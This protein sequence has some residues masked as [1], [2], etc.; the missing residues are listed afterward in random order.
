MADFTILMKTAEQNGGRV[1]KR[2][3]PCA[4]LSR[5]GR[6]LVNAETFELIKPAA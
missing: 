1:R 6:V 2:R 5:A 3:T 4:R